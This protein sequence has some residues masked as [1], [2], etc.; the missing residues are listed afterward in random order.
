MASVLDGL[1]ELYAC[2]GIG[3]GLGFLLERRGVRG[4]V[5]KIL[6]W[7]V[8]NAV[9]P[10][11]VFTSL[12]KNAANIPWEN[13]ASTVVVMVV[14]SMGSMGI[15]YASLRKRKGMTGP[16]LGGYLLI[17]GWANATFFPVPVVLAVFGA[18]FL[19]YPILYA[20]TSLILR[21][22]VA[23]YLCIKLGANPGERISAKETARALI[24][25]PPTVAIAIALLYVLAGPPLSPEL[26]GAI[27]LP[28][29]RVSSWLGAATIGMFLNGVDLAKA[30]ELKRDIPLSMAFRFALPLLIFLPLSLVLPVASDPMTVKTILLLAV[31][32]PPA[33][34]NTLFAARFRLDKE[35]VA[36]SVV[37]LTVLMIVLTPII[38]LV[39]SA[40][41]T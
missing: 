37:V 4:L 40:L 41:F 29:A 1:L 23:T 38:L 12:V 21:G 16:R 36:M 32:S 3:L 14:T 31:L 33:I 39:G 24:T 5:E 34:I 11:L 30:K 7:I 10:A 18:D 8:I 2:I 27:E 15:A 13:L 6:T 25:F 9:T 17:A 20:S 22:T 19:I 28:I 35:L 26:L